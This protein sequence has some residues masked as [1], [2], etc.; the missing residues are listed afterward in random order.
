MS[1]VKA[2]VANATRPRLT[3]A[4]LTQKVISTD[5]DIVE[6]MIP[7]ALAMGMTAEVALKTLVVHLRS[8][9]VDPASVGRIPT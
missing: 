2:E 1:D 5:A 6:K 8:Q 7:M 4:E 9:A 3:Y